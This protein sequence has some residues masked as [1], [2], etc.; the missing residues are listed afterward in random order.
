MGS[1]VPVY[2]GKV[3]HR[4]WPQLPEELV[5]SVIDISATRAQELIEHLPNRHIATFYL[6]D[7]SVTNYCPQVWEAR[8]N[9]HHRMVY[10]ALRDALELERH[11]MSICP[12]W[13]IAREF[14]TSTYCGDFNM[15]TN[16][17]QI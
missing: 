8:E 7:Q 10:T 17:S 13:Y 1:P 16:S 11:L 4:S 14:T 2:K 5:R 12:Q 3:T 6:W 9:W 15:L